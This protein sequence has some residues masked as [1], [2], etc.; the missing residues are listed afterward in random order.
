MTALSDAV[1][2][3]VTDIGEDALDSSLDAV[4]QAADSKVRDIIKDVTGVEVK[5]T[6]DINEDLL[7]KIQANE[8]AFLEKLKERNR[9]EEYMAKLELDKYAK[10]VLP[11]CSSQ[12][13]Y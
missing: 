10:H 5:S 6:D 9:H 4:K 7:A 8:E 1:V 11:P 13:L 3:T 12:S 2:D